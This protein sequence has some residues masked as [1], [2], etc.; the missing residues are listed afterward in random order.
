AAVD[1]EGAVFWNKEKM[2]D[3]RE[4]LDR[5]KEVAVLEPQPEVHVRGDRN[6]GFEFIGRV[7]VTC[8]RDGIQK[9]AFI[10]EPVSGAAQQE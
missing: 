9:V 8:Q 3:N 5:I 2:A 4:L 1:G 10:T 7:T 6:T